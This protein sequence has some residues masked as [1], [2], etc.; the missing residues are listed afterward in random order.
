VQLY[1]SSFSCIFHGNVAT[2][3]A[4]FHSY[5]RDYHGIQPSW[6]V[7]WLGNTIEEGNGYDS[8]H[9]LL[10]RDAKL[11]VMAAHH[12]GPDFAHVLNLGT[13]VRNNQ[14]LSNAAIRIGLKEVTSPSVRDVIVE[15]NLVRDNDSGIEVG[16]GV[17]G[18]CLRGNH[19]ERVEKPLL[20]HEPEKVLLLPEKPNSAVLQQ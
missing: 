4:G 11:G 7:Q 18:V 1:G 15:G 10:P 13:V 2:R 5:G 19:F 17:Q 8:A 12:R 20:L 16:P 9:R 6:R 3:T 14:L